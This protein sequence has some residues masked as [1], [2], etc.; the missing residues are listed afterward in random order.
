M[1]RV[2]KSNFNFHPT[3]KSI[4]MV[5]YCQVVCLIRN[6]GNRKLDSDGGDEDGLTW[7]FY[8]CLRKDPR[9]KMG[10]AGPF[11]L[12]STTIPLFIGMLMFSGWILRLMH[13][14][15]LLSTREDSSEGDV[16]C[17]LSAA[18][19]KDPGESRTQMAG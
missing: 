3:Q 13:G 10:V 2:T 14:D 9:G 15:K 17:N 6:P 12:K 4:V 8:S 7:T 16:F 19:L 18:E 11:Y 1:K 5:L